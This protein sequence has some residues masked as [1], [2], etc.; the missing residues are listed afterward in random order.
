MSKYE[1]DFQLCQNSRIEGNVR[2]IIE[3]LCDYIFRFFDA[4]E[5]EA[6]LLIGSFS[7]GEG[8]IYISDED[9]SVY[10]SDFEFLTVYKDEKKFAAFRKKLVE[11]NE[12]T[13]KDFFEMGV[14]IEVDFGPYLTKFFKMMRPRMFTTDILRCGKVVWG[15]KEVLR[16]IPKGIAEENIPKDDALFLLFNRI[17][18]QTMLLESV[19]PEEK[20]DY[21]KTVYKLG[22]TYLD[23][24]TTLMAFSGKY[25]C[26]Y[27][28]RAR[29][30][31]EFWEGL[32]SGYL[33]NNLA[34]LP[35]KIDYWSKFRSRPFSEGFEFEGNI[36]DMYLDLIK[37]CAPIFVWVMNNYS[38]CNWSEDIGRLIE[39][40]FKEERLLTKLKGWVKLARHPYFKEKNLPVARL[41]RLLA[42]GS[43]KK[44]IYLS[45]CRFYF[46]LPNIIQNNA[47]LESAEIKNL[48]NT[49]PV[50]FEES[51]DVD[52]VLKVLKNNLVENW[53]IFLK[54]DW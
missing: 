26:G 52:E 3:Q 14:D 12:M 8:S 31:N 50:I 2:K 40:G 54:S 4:S 53:K 20:G 10:L 30:F 46:E 42:K 45:S 17:I 51:S 43:P 29:H 34:D 37:T 47:R 15:N 27:S 22:K 18:E 28:E 49:L 36:L 44:L 16:N 41:L 9:K 6:I 33:K 23:F 32:D 35:S 1:L 25:K 21:R 48:L 13:R 24:I 5:I 39:V 19:Y 11:I 38:N 7:K